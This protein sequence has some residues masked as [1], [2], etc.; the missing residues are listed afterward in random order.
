MEV[1]DCNNR[2]IYFDKSRIDIDIDGAGKLV[3]I[4][5]GDL[6]DVTD[7][8]ASYR[9]TNRGRLMIYVRRIGKGD[10]RVKASNPYLKE[11]II[12]V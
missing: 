9:D 4:D 10:I 3:A 2:N 11:D 5:N 12:I 1:L 8:T 7:Y 6:R